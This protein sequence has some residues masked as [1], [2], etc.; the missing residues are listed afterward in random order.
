MIFVTSDDMD[1]A[2]DMYNLGADYVILPH[3]LGA[4]HVSVL[5]EDLTADVTKILNNKLNHIT[6]LKKRLRLGHAHPRRNH[7]GN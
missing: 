3:F 6:E 2:L 7:H 5:L 4:E 1:Q